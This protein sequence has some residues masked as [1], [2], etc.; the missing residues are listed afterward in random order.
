MSR[1]RI[2]DRS[3]SP[4][5][6]TTPSSATSGHDKAR[7]EAELAC[8]DGHRP[9]HRRPWRGR[10]RPACPGL[11]FEKYCVEEATYGTRS[12]E[13]DRPWARCSHLAGMIPT[14]PATQEL[15]SRKILNA[16]LSAICLTRRSFFSSIERAFKEELRN[17]GIRSGD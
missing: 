17:L 14:V 2:A 13:P 15:G 11:R 12:P 9:A 16:L 10:V 7:G 6:D 3:G 5:G 8:E 1:S 4:S